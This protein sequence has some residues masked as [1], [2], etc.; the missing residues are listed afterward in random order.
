MMALFSIRIE[1]II[2]YAWS[3]SQKEV[4]M[5][6]LPIAS[7]IAFVLTSTSLRAEEKPIKVFILA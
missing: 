4:V 6:R 1:A 7:L 5:A 2:Q 3:S